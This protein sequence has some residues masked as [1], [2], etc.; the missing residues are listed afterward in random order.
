MRVYLLLIFSFILIPINSQVRRNTSQDSP[1]QKLE[2]H[3]IGEGHIVIRQSPD[4]GQMMENYIS[5]NKSL[6]GIEG[7]R[8]H[9]YSGT[10]VNARQEAYEIRT[11]L[12]SKFPDERVIVEFNAPFWRVRI[13]SFRHKHEA[14]PL[15][16]RIRNSMPN[17]GGYVVRDSSI[18]LDEFKN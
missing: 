5:S 8:I 16:R 18:K 1:F 7:Y 14:L 6:P 12:L 17:I 13:G 2:K 4:V 10:D 3:N 9:L 15:L 11:A